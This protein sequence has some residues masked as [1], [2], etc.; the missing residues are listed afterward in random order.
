MIFLGALVL[1]ITANSG[2]TSAQDESPYLRKVRAIETRKFGLTATVGLAYSPEAKALLLIEGP[3]TGA[4]PSGR[5]DVVMISL[6]REPM[7]TISVAADI[8]DPLNISFSRRANGLLALDRTTN[9]LIKI[10]AGPDG[11]LDPSEKAVTRFDVGRFAIQNPLGITADQES[12]DLYVLDAN[13]PRI[14]R[15][16]PGPEQDFSRAASEWIPTPAVRMCGSVWAGRIAFNQQNR[17]LYLFNPVDQK[18]LELTGEGE[19]VSVRDLTSLNLAGPQ[20]MLFASSVDQTDDPSIMDLYIAD[21]GFNVIQGQSRSEV[22]ELS[23]TAPELSESF[24]EAASV[25]VSLANTILSSQWSPP[26]PDPAGIDFHPESGTYW[27][28]DSEVEEMSIYAGVNIWVMTPSGY[29]LST[30]KTMPFSPEPTGLAHNP[31][32]GRI[33]ISDDDWR[34]IFEVNLGADGVYG[35][36]DDTVR[37]IS[38]SSYGSIDPEGVAFDGARGMLFIS[39]GENG[40]V[41]KITPGADGIFNGTPPAGDDQMTHFDTSSIG[42]PDAEAIEYNPDSGTIYI[43]GPSSRRT[44]VEAN[45][46]GTVVRT[47]EITAAMT[48]APAGL[49]YGTGS[50][51]AKHIYLTDRF[52]D[53][54]PYPNENDGRIFDFSIPWPI[55]TGFSPSGG[56]VG[57]LVT[58]TGNK[59]TG[60]TAVTFQGANAAFAVVSDT[61]IT[62]TV[63]A[64][65]TTGKISVTTLAG[66]GSN[67]SDFTVTSAGLHDVA[68]TGV[69]A[70]TPVIV[71]TAQ[72][73]TVNVA[74]QGNET[75]TFTVTLADSL[76][77][78]VGGPQT[79]TNLAGG[80][81]QTLTFAWTP[82]AIGTHTLTAT[83]STVT[84][85]TDTAD[86]VRT[87]TSAVN[88][89]PPIVTSFSP[90]AG[91]VGTSVTV[92][93]AHFT[94]AT[95]VAF[96][97]TSA[98]FTVLSDT[99][100]TATVPPNATTGRITVTTPVGTGSSSSDFTVTAAPTVISI[101]P[102]TIKA[103]TGG[104]VTLTGTNFAS[105]ATL[106]FQNGIGPAPVASNIVVL[107][108]G[109]NMTATITVKSGGP[110]RSRV[111]DV[112]VTNPDGSRGT[113]I[114]GFTVTP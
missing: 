107:N 34:R 35:T 96:N 44:I 54:G 14:V 114:R 48:S 68:V 13:G 87:A 60:A 71:N 104:S 23:L 62:A 63:P 15:L 26:S 52:L 47:I 20:A 92:T 75:E 38:A 66:T 82:T 88:S 45:L 69:T 42:V 94:G 36:A 95:R 11:R 89:A 77:A 84:G 112:V 83:A 43:T 110:S 113:L 111:W 64:G 55:I 86:N 101:V 25:P 85:E 105:G 1:F 46:D 102:N 57:T 97:N 10:S 39:D 7:G 50:S 90:T 22:V 4:P 8:L 29:V 74:N 103:G 19:V 24:L 12:G 37:Y 40:E 28:S 5:C 49:A 18:L 67:V 33:F 53:N 59:F 31:S 61:S 58:L 78:T 108:G 98:T 99:S 30:G 65:A 41:Y 80:G 73:V 2:V 32:N 16:I 6:L 76:A 9:K 17:H 72:T 106:T 70:P 27:V 56:P 93:G 21:S 51:G 100:L 91:P 79:V 81:T 109:Q 3:K